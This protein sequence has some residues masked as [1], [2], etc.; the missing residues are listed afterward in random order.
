MELTFDKALYDKRALLKAAYQFTDRAYLHLSQDGAHWHVAWTPK[1][2]CAVR[3]EELENELI[4]QSLRLQLT[5]ESADVRRILL[6]RAMASTLIGTPPQEPG[7]P[8]T[9]EGAQEILKGWY[10]HDV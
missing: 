10:E 9:D 3:P 4:H 6:A 5:Q 7:L 2:G 1:E 8:G